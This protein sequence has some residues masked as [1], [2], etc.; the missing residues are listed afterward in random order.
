MIDENYIW[1]GGAGYI[2]ALKDL[3]DTYLVSI[4]HYLRT[5][6]PRWK[7]MNGLNLDREVLYR[8]HEMCTILQRIYRERGLGEIQPSP[9][10]PSSFRKPRTGKSLEEQYFEAHPIEELG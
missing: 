1:R 7:Y 8:R 9:S 10:A 4:Y 2:S 5:Y 3:P 6:L